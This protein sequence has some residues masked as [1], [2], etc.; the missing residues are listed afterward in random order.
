MSKVA[1]KVSN[2][3]KRCVYEIAIIFQRTENI[4]GLSLYNKFVISVC[5]LGGRLVPINLLVT[6]Q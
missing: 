4:R 5:F 3:S 6:G 1:K 2:E